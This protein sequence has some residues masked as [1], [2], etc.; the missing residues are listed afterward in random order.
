[1]ACLFALVALAEPTQ[2][3]GLFAGNAVG[4]VI[5]RRRPIVLQ[6]LR[7]IRLCST[8]LTVGGFL[9]L[10]ILVAGVNLGVGGSNDSS[11]IA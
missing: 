8:Y 11:R 7:V 3:V 4:L 6:A 1:M 2:V 9:L 5:P 10:V